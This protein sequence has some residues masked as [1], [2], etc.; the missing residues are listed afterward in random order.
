MTDK[1]KLIEVLNASF[2]EQYEKRGLITAQHTADY[3]IENRI[4]P[5]KSTPTNEYKE[6]IESLIAGQETL[7]KYIA[8]K[9][10]EIEN[11]NTE[12]TI[13]RIRRKNAVDAYH[14][15]KDKNQNIKQ[16]RS[17][18]EWGADKIVSTIETTEY[19]NIKEIKS[20]SVKEFAERLKDED[21][22]SLHDDGY[23][24]WVNYDSFIERIDN[25]KKEMV[26]E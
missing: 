26:G 24:I 19:Q 14:E 13:E 23:D 6:Q 11:L 3:L 8:E 4:T 12:L 17:K 18:S 1:E 20:E 5:E 10:A 7:Q 16:K 22:L 15:E 21:N 9:D 25:I 2:A